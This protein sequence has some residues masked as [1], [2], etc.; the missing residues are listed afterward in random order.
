[1]LS[2]QD[3]EGSKAK[4]MPI[5]LVIGFAL[6]EITT[7]ITDGRIINL[8]HVWTNSII[9]SEYQVALSGDAV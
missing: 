9:D 1:M 2:N 3:A 8:H 5:T 6:I 4:A 7:H